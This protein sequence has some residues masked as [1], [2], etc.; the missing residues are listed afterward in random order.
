MTEYQLGWILVLIIIPFTLLALYRRREQKIFKA[1]L[2]AAELA[3]QDQEMSEKKKKK[4]AEL[5]VKLIHQGTDHYL[6]EL[7]NSG[8]VILKNI[9]MDLLL[10]ENQANPL[11]LAEYTKKFPI[12]RLVAGK[13]VTV[14]A[15]QYATSPTTYNVRV[16]WT[17]PDGSRV[18]DQL[19]VGV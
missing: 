16:R 5:S 11:V 18:E 2:L 10:D 15:V 8:N 13:S 7:L 1:R 3:L 14:T 12:R 4:K 17:E 9:E 6:L 19:Y